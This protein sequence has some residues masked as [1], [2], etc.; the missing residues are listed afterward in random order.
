MKIQHAIKEALRNP[1]TLARIQQKAQ[2]ALAMDSIETEED[3]SV[4]RTLLEEFR[5]TPEELAAL[6]M[7]RVMAVGTNT[8][9]IPTT[10]SLVANAAASTAVCTMTTT[11]TTTSIACNEV[12]L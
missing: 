12:L 10:T 2:A 3:Q 1:D 5:A 6:T 8:S 9:G 7:P 4:W 11:T